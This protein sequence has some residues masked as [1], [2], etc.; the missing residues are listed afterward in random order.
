[1]RRIQFIWVLDKEF[2]YFF[3]KWVNETQ[4]KQLTWTV[5]CLFAFASSHWS[6]AQ[7][8]T[9]TVYNDTPLISIINEKLKLFY[10]T[11]KKI[12]LKHEELH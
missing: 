11:I 4:I 1:M 6:S 5:A 10:E 2:D 3:S 8:K 7:L 9:E 12:I